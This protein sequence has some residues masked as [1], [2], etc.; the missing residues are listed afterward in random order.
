MTEGHDRLLR[1]RD[2]IAAGERRKIVEAITAANPDVSGDLMRH[3]DLRGVGDVI[4][5]GMEI[6]RS[7]RRSRYVPGWRP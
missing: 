1:F 6:G 5:E 4:R 2:R 3:L 7:L